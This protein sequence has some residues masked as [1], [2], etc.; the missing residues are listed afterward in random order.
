MKDQKAMDDAMQ[1]YHEWTCLVQSKNERLLKAIESVKGLDFVN[2]LKDWTDRFMEDNIGMVPVELMLTNKPSGNQQTSDLDSENIPF[3][4]VDQ[5]ENG[6]IS[7]D[8]F[9]GYAYVKIR[10]NKFI[11][12]HYSM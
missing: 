1:E 8:S 5:Y 9:S 6:G 12:I 2:D 7:G 4:W 11:Q 3:E 10:E